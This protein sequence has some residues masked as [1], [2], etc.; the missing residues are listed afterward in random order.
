MLWDNVIKFY[1]CRYMGVATG[2]VRGVATRVDTDMIMDVATGVITDVTTVVTTDTV[3]GVAMG[4]TMGVVNAEFQWVPKCV[5]L[6]Y[7]SNEPS[8]IV[9]GQSV[10]NVILYLWVWH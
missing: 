9:V 4:V 8:Y 1:F 5:Q 10:R 2:M 6:S 3:T 7:I